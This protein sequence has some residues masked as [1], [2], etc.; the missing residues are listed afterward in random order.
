MLVPDP[1]FLPFFIYG[2]LMPGERNHFPLLHESIIRCEEASILGT[3][4]YYRTEDCP[5]LTE[6]KTPISGQ[7]LMLRAENFPE[8]LSR[9]NKIEGYI[10]PGD[11]KNVYNLE[12]ADVQPAKGETVRAYVYRINPVLLREHPEAFSV[13]AEHSWRAFRKKH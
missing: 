7:L 2:T 10:A 3:L 5:A 11:P 12:T 9:M 6:G 4:Y 8:I 1:Q 13:M